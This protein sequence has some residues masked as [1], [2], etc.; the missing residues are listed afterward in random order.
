M[1]LIGILVVLVIVGVILYLVNSVIPM[2]PWMKTIIN[3]LAGIFVLL[4]LLQVFGLY[5]TSIFRPR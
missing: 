1:N 3:A 4:W 2:V 5:E